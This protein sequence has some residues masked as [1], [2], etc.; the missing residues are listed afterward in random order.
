MDEHHVSKK[1]DYLFVALFFIG[2]VL[3]VLVIYL[4]PLKHL[5]LVEPKIKAMHPVEFYTAFKENPDAYLF[6]DVRPNSEYDREHAEGSINIPLVSLFIE[7]HFLPKKGKTIIL[8]CSGRSASGVVYQYLEHN[9]FLNLRRIENKE[10]GL[11][12]IRSWRE[13]GL[14]LE[15]SLVGSEERS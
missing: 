8:I 11:F 1:R 2:V 7:R 13:A 6:I 9:G 14:P 12:G 10:N 4:T 15:G 5:N 3:S